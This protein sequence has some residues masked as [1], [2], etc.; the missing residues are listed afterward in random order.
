MPDDYQRS[1]ELLFAIVLG[2]M[3]WKGVEAD[4]CDR[5]K[6]DRRTTTIIPRGDFNAELLRKC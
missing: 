3:R 5:E 6:D 2:C 1:I 4:E